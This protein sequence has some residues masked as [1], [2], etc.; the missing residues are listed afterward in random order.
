[1]PPRDLEP[2][3]GGGTALGDDPMANVPAWVATGIPADLLQRRPDIRSAERQIAAQSALIGVA[4]A[5]LYPTFYID[6]TLGW[7]AT[8]FDKV[9]EPRSFFGTISPGFQWN[10][11]NYGRIENNVYLQRAKTQEFIALYQNRVLTAAQ[12]VQTSLRGFLRSRQQVDALS[13]GVKAAVRA[14]QVGVGQYRGGIIDFTTVL[15]IQTSQVNAQ[16]A[17]AVAQ[18]N[19]ALNLIGVYR[20]LGGGWEI[21]FAKNNTAPIASTQPTEALATSQSGPAQAMR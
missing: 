7:Q 5:D 2:E 21:R 15:Q 10:I 9:F 18:G 13:L 6:G 4:E 17:L 20:A 3:L 14:T 19:I 1:V 16:D 12:E 8:D 11:L